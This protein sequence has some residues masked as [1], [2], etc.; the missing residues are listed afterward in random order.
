MRGYCSANSQFKPYINNKYSDEELNKM[1][2]KSEHK[3]NCLNQNIF[4][5]EKTNKD[6][7]TIV[8]NLKN[9]IDIKNKTK[10]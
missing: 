10:Y 1:F 9:Y 8:H 2:G 4:E 3:K 7:E 6:L 5:F